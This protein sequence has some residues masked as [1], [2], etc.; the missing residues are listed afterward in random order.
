MTYKKTLSEKEKD[1]TFNQM[2]QNNDI[3]ISVNKTNF[4]LSGLKNKQQKSAA[5]FN[6]MR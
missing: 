2:V 3:F 6:S 5:A 4:K 1:T